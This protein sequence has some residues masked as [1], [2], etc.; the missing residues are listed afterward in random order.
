MNIYTV[1][2]RFLMSVCLTVCSTGLTSFSQSALAQSYPCSDVSLG[3]NTYERDQGYQ[4]NNNESY[5]Q[6]NIQL[7]D[8]RL[9]R[10]D[11]AMDLE[12]SNR[13]GSSSQGTNNSGSS[14][15]S[16]TNADSTSSSSSRANSQRVAGGGSYAGVGANVDYST[17]NSSN[18]SNS[19][20]NFENETGRSDFDR[21]QNSQNE[22]NSQSSRD[23][24]RIDETSTYNSTSND[25]SSSGSFNRDRRQNDYARTG[26]TVVGMNCD[27]AVQAES[28]R[29]REGLRQRGAVEQ[30]RLRLQ[31]EERRQQSSDDYWNSPW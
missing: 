16:N 9:S 12:S 14:A 23:G 1:T 30:E 25:R 15:S 26:T 11:N 13:S 6:T 18:R 4:Q 27:R 7:G 21:S 3:T 10:R 8:Q 2:P 20:S 22:S 5:S 17:S 28:E 31:R 19:Q 24:S 29:D